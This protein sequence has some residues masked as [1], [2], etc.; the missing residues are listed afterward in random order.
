MKKKVIMIL[1]TILIVVIIFILGRFHFSSTYFLGRDISVNKINEI[2]C[3]F[4]KYNGGGI[5]SLNIDF[6]EFKK[7]N[8][9]IK[10]DT[11]Y[12]GET[13]IAIATR[14]V[15]RCFKDYELTLKSFDGRQTQYYV[16]K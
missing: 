6:I 4:W 7:S 12:F 14:L 15:H 13:P 9:K 10:N 11:L 16:S 5:D 1:T 3:G 8:R 2:D